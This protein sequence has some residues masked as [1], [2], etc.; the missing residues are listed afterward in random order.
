MERK[1]AATRVDAL[2]DSRQARVRAARLD[3]VCPEG[4]PGGV[5]LAIEE[6]DVVL[7]NEEMRGV[8]RGCRPVTEI[9]V[10]DGEDDWSPAGDLRAGRRVRERDVDGLVTFGE[11]VVGDEDVEALRGFTRCEAQSTDGGGVV[12]AVVGRAV[13]G[14]VVNRHRGCEVS[15]ERVTMSWNLEPTP[16]F[17]R[18]SRR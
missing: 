9:V 3:V 7:A 18:S 2:L 1:K 11:G 16:S 15:P 6:V 17:A 10:N 8:D 12:A 4:E 5:R 14:G 13:R